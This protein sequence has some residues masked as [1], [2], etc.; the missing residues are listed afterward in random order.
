MSTALLHVKAYTDRLFASNFVE[1]EVQLS[2]GS[3]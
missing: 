1:S 2:A 3:V